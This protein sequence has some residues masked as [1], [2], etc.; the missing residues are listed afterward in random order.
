[1]K[2]ANGPKNKKNLITH[3]MT[4]P[5]AAGKNI[6]N[7]SVACGWWSEVP[8]YLD[9]EPKHYRIR[10]CPIVVLELELGIRLKVKKL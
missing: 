10:I 2:K 3:L 5:Q 9:L 4:M 8:G 1:M 6:V 7:S